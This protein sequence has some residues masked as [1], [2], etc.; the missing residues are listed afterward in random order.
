VGG[1][2]PKKARA[3]AEGA[4]WETRVEEG[5]TEVPIHC[6]GEGCSERTWIVFPGKGSFGG[7]VLRDKGWSVLNNPGEVEVIFWCPACFE[8]EIAKLAGSDHL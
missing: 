1:T 3:A 8:K 5:L 6:L 4:N 2:G 7:A